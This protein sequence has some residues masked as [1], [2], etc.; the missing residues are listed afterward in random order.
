[1]VN[2]SN[3]VEEKKVKEL[4]LS[5]VGTSNN[6]EKAGAKCSHCQGSQAQGSSKEAGKVPALQQGGPFEG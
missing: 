1:M 4:T 3:K 2:V 6:K 5:N